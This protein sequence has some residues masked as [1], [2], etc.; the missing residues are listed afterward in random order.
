MEFSRK[1]YWSG[2]PF[3]SAG[4][5]PNAGIEPGTPALQADALP[6][7][8][9][10]HEAKAN[11]SDTIKLMPALPTYRM[12]TTWLISCQAIDVNYSWDFHEHYLHF[13]A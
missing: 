9:T 2:S 5:L 6:T 12:F 3:P 4:D 13:A 7:E 1:E 10:W 11:T 8:L